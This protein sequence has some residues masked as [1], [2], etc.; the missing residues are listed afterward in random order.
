[1]GMA[2]QDDRWF[3]ASENARVE[4]LCF[5]WGIEL[6]VG[7]A[8]GAF[9]IRIEGP[10]VLTGPGGT[11]MPLDPAADPA[12]LAAVLAVVRQ[13][14]R[15]VAA[16]KDG[17]LVIAFSDDSGLSVPADDSFEPWTIACPNGMKIVSVPGGG[18]AIWKAENDR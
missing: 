4:R 8:D 17:R 16:L 1:M 10:C 9:D 3:L 2:E 15:S 7:A 13:G 11:E 12:G 18:L 6:A 14:V 5:D